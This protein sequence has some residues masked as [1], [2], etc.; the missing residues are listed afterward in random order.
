M[1]DRM[2]YF[3][4]SLL[5]LLLVS[6]DTNSIGSRSYEVFKDQSIRFDENMNSD[7]DDFLIMDNGR[8]ALKKITI[9]IFKKHTD[10]LL[11]LIHI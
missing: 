10:V 1:Q 7:S 4:M 5:F 6:C 9:P 8:I 2:F 11:S 3:L